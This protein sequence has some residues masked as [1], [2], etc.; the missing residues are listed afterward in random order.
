MVGTNGSAFPAPATRADR[1]LRHLNRLTQSLSHIPP[2]AIRQRSDAV[3]NALGR[4]SGHEHSYRGSTLQTSDGPVLQ[5]AIQLL[6]WGMRRNRRHDHIVQAVIGQCG[7]DH[8]GSSDLRQPIP[9]RK[10]DQHDVT[11]L[12]DRRASASRRR[13]RPRDCSRQRRKLPQRPLTKRRLHRAG[14]SRI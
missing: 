14:G 6:P 13:P 7:D 12:P 8:G 10:R 1:W 5:E 11:G 9:E 4:Q 2:I 3:Q